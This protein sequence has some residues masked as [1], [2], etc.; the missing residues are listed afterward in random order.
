MSQTTLQA[1]D[2]KTKLPTTRDETAENG[3]SFKTIVDAINTMFSELYANEAARAALEAAESAIKFVDVTVTAAQMLALNA[4]PKQ[5]VAAPGA[6]LAL[7]FE[8]A[9]VFL[10]YG[11]AAYAGIASGEDLAVKYTDS[12][13][14]Q[15]ASCETD[16]FLTA[17]ADATRYIHPYKAASG[18][19]AITPLEN[20]ALVLH[21]LSGEITTGDSP[22]KLR[23]YYR[24]IPFTL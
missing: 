11:T 13:G 2:S 8:G 12:S 16:P 17:T 5:L 14:L 18:N 23:V 21:M 15:V 10:D 6:G 9:V 19:S 1:P 22:V 24:T 20:A 3:Q 7:V 4:T